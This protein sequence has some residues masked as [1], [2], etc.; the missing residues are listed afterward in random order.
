MA[1][2]V[3][4]R[5]VWT[6]GAQGPGPLRKGRMSTDQSRPQKDSVPPLLDPSD[7]SPALDASDLE[8]QLR[9]TLSVLR[10]A[11]DSTGDGILIVD[12]SG[13]MV[14]FNRQ[15]AE[16]WGLPEQILRSRS[17]RD[18]LD[19]AVERVKSPEV[20]LSRVEYLYANPDERSFDL[21]ELKDGR[22]LERY[23]Q[24]HQ[25]GNEVLGRIWSFRDVTER[26]RAEAE[27]R[28]SEKRYRGL[29]EDSRQAIYLTTRDGVFIDAN[30]AALRMFGLGGE[31]MAELNARDL[32]VDPR[33]R[34]A[35][36][37]AIE[38]RGAVV[39]Y[40]VLLRGKDGAEMECLLSSTVWVDA[41][42]EI[43]GYQGII[44]NVTERNRAERALREN[45]QKFRSLI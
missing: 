42:G 12:Q 11:L 41:A 24:P 32:Y 1:P 39:D 36:R 23:S 25:M 35:F 33:A 14:T 29:F 4:G 3:S 30:P 45:E 13:T 5:R 19:A 21:V 28:S 9:R 34:A 7:L 38:D 16:M 43:Q 18:A 10:G 40:P 2:G 6:Q 22:I 17:D 27:L 37:H 31:E 44:E 26:A 20:F 8:D 15:F